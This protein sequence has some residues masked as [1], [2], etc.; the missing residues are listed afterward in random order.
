MTQS[1]KNR[2]D[3]IV[4]IQEYYAQG[5]T[6]ASIIKLMK[7]NHNTINRY[8]Q[9]DPYKLCRFDSSGMKTVNYENYRED[10]I[11]YLQTDMPFTVIYEK[12]KAA[13]YNGKLTQ[14]RQYCRKLI[15]ERGI[16]Y[17]SRKNSSGVTIKK[18]Q[19]FDVHCIKKVDLF[20]YIWS[21]NELDFHD[22]VYIIRKY[23]AVLDIIECVRDFRN[24]YIEKSGDFL[25]Q[26]I[27]KYSESS[28]KSI[29]SFAKGLLLDY[30]AVK[31]SVVSDLS[32]GFV[33]GCNNKIK[34]IKRSMYGRAKIDLLR[35]KV[36][37]SK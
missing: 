8:K 29:K 36:L 7:M 37:H 12:I 11:E 16:E 30:D 31:N 4:Q 33:E 2:Y 15:G 1:E 20:Q 35:V 3:R 34:L 10:I 5:Y 17:N 19:K 18:N 24:I 32:N 27:N 21:D 23:P 25:N 13:G 22:V 28:V 9:G 26:F 14:I 6:Q